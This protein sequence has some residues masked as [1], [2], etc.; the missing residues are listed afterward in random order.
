VEIIFPVVVEKSILV[1]IDGFKSEIFNLRV[2]F[3]IK[4][5]L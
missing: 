1:I 4:N 2:C 3:G 5:N